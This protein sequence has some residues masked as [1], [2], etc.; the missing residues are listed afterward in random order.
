[1]KKRLKWLGMMNRTT[2]EERVQWFIQSFSGIKEIKAASK[3][4]YFIKG[5]RDSYTEYAGIYY[6]SAY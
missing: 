4:E 2:Y 1:M 3:E 5:Y 6:K